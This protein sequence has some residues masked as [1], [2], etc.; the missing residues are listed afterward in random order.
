MSEG[1]PAAGRQG[2][3]PAREWVRPAAPPTTTIPG[4]RARPQTVPGLR[5]DPSPVLPAPSPGIPLSHLPAK[6]RSPQPATVALPLPT[7]SRRWSPT[8]ELWGPRSPRP[9]VATPRPRT[10]PP[11]PLPGG[12]GATPPP[13]AVNLPCF[14]PPSFG[15]TSTLGPAHSP[16]LTNEPAC[17]APSNDW[18]ARPRF[19]KWALFPG[20]VYSEDAAGQTD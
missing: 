12:P 8:A 6:R 3:G 15:R 2:R 13:A 20:N 18:L 19:Q 17:P 7:I 5:G 4:L 9:M 11:Y 14:A 10:P 16:N 1:A